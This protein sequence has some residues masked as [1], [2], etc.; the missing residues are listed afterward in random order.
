MPNCR[1]NVNIMAKI[2]VTEHTS[3]IDKAIYE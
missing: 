3:G 1:K 2:V